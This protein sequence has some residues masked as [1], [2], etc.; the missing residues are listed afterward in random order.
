MCMKV[1]VFIC[2]CLSGGVS[3]AG[4]HVVD[5]NV[6]RSIHVSCACI[7]RLYISVVRAW[8]YLKVSVKSGIESLRENRP[9]FA[10]SQYLYSTGN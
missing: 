1:H 4:Q 2:V 7:P 6:I 9:F 5:G 8:G 10:L 3:G